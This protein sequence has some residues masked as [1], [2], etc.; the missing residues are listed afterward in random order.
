MDLQL[1]AALADINAK[2]DNLIQTPDFHNQRMKKG[3][4]AS[5]QHT[6]EQPPLQPYTMCD[7]QHTINQRAPNV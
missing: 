1:P 7:I 3:A 4:P 6:T 2:L 5:E